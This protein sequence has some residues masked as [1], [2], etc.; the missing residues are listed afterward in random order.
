MRVVGQ[1]E[2]P[3]AVAGV[4]VPGSGVRGGDD[5]QRYG[6]RQPVGDR[7]EV[8]TTPATAGPASAVP[9]PGPVRQRRVRRGYVAAG[10]LAVGI[11]AIGSPRLFTAVPPDG[12]HLVWSAE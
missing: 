3:G 2:A 1:W 11:A 8:T 7:M 5:G 10:V 6:R 12:V 9:V 4:P